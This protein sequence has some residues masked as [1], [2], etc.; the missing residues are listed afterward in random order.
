MTPGQNMALWQLQ[1]I[2]AA[3]DHSLTIEK[4]DEPTPSKPSLKV[5]VSLHIG[6]VPFAE[7]GLRLRERETF[8]FVIFPQFPFQKPGVFVS[9]TRFAG[10]PHVQWKH[11]LCLFQSATEW[12]ASDGMFGLIDRLEHWLRQGALNALDPVGQPLHPPVVYTD[13]ET[14][15]LF[16]P[17]KD[18]PTFEGPYW[19]GLAGLHDFPTRVEINE[20]FDPTNIPYEGECAL[21]VLFANPLPWEYPTNGADFFRECEQQGIQKEFLFRLL[22]VA[23]R[24]TPNG[25][26]IYFVFGSPMRGIAGGPR[27]QHLSVW[28][29]DAKKADSIRNTIAKPGDPAEIAAI[30]EGLEEILIELLEASKIAW[31]PVREAR[32]EVT[33]RR[34]HN[35]PLSYFQGRSVSIWGC[36]AL[37][38]QIALCLCR[39]GVKRLIL[40][41]NATVTPG[42]LVRQPYEYEDI[43]NTK[44]FALRNHLLAI[45]PDLDIQVDEEDIATKLSEREF[46]WS[47]GAEV[48]IDATAS[49]LVR[50]RLEMIWHSSGTRR[51]PV[52]LLMLDHNAQRLITAI[53][54]TEFSGAAWDVLRRAKI[55]ILRDQ[56]LS[57]FADSF[58]PSTVTQNIFQPEPGCSDPTFIGSA[59]DAVSLA[60]IG[61]NLIA[62]ELAKNP[63]VNAISHVFAQPTD[64]TTAI[65]RLAARFEFHADLLLVL[66]GHQIRISQAAIRE[67]KAWTAQNRR[68]R[69]RKVETGG[70]LWGEWDEATGIVWVT[71]ASGPPPDSRHSEE[72]F[73]C[74][75]VGTAVEHER[76]TKLSRFSTSYIGMWH[77]HPISRPL[78]SGTDIEGMHHILTSG[79]LP[80][81]KN[82]LLIIGKDA[83][84]DTLGAYLFR[85]LKGDALGALHEMRTGRLHLQE[86]IL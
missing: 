37:G 54:G 22:K 12:N 3:D 26:P 74:G 60:S 29:I 45:R 86:S 72:M 79:T 64:A 14:G 19:L 48:L 4:I 15:K 80:V 50:K 52:A 44:V 38:A 85:R 73:L 84:Q 46:E 18:T 31:C 43:G 6:P 2:A 34:D 25:Q 32:P 61:L 71:D 28:A 39:A 59:A 36:G 7:G 35:A 77:T 49:D 56:S 42:I 66:D 65:G 5:T 11:Y 70:L 63:S 78:P 23:S 83:G 67:I 20:W 51:V 81:R 13:S 27:K 82:L 68:L 24:L 8:L 1:E 10:M 47:D 58:F 17:C 53:V 41:D 62:Q 40:R 57:P 55:E 76:R 69:N 21:A 16:V 75:V 30:R 9:H 33:I